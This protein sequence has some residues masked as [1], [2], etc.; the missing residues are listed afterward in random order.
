MNTITVEKQM[1]LDALNENREEHRSIFER[2]QEVY[3]AE[4]IKQLDQALEDARNGKKIVT[5][6]Y[7]PQPED[8]TQDFDT[9]IRMIQWHRGDT[10]EIEQGDF[11]C[12]VENKWRWRQ[13]FAGNTESYLVQ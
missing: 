1:L 2:A 6:I 11:E 13:A 8:H 4:V 7:L 10:I 12:Y 5:A 9:A 3:R